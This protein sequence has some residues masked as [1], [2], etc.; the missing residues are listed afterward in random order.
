MS[1]IEL[2]GVRS[3]SITGLLIQSLPPITKP[4][5]RIETETIDGRAGDIINELGYAAYDRVAMIGL[6]GKYNIDDV[7]QFFNSSGSAVFSNEPDK[8][9]QYRITQQIDFE[10]LIRFKTA[11]VTFH[12]QPYKMSAA[13]APV[14]IETEETSGIISV[15]NIGNVFAQPKLTIYGEDDI[16]IYLD[17]VQ[18]FAIAL[19]DDGYIVIDTDKAEA[20]QGNTLKNRLVTGD[21]SKMTLPTGV[22]AISWSGAVNK[23]IVEN[24]SRWI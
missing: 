16:S 19:G 2:N 24:Y 22:S 1:Y 20:Y 9:Y 12:V 21:Y 23:I 4:Q 6:Y 13:L 3:T 17:G 8:V 14:E 18:L 5:M 15:N 10:R 11:M 7:I